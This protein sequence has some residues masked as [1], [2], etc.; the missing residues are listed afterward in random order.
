MSAETDLKANNILKNIAK[1]ITFTG[2][3]KEEIFDDTKRIAKIL[4]N[5]VRSADPLSPY[6]SPVNR[7][8]SAKKF[9]GDVFNAVHRATEIK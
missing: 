4:V 9:W 5:E 7:F 2:Q 3:S 6:H 8:V 1:E